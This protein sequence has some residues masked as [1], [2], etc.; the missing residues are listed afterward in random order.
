MTRVPDSELVGDRENLRLPP[1]CT[2]RG[3]TIMVRTRTRAEYIDCLEWCRSQG[4]DLRDGGARGFWWDDP[5]TPRLSWSISPPQD[6]EDEEFLDYPRLRAR[7]APDT[8]LPW[9]RPRR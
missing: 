3:A 9:N 5:D 1:Y 7:H 2:A 6:V 8:S 4:G